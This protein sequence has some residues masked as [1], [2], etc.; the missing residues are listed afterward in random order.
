VLACQEKNI[1]AAKAEKIKV[2]LETGK[3]MTSKLSSI[4]IKLKN[5]FSWIPNCNI[6]KT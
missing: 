1:G 6:L 3:R 2:V 5:L 4:K